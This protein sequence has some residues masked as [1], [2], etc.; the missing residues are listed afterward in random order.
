MVLNKSDLVEDPAS[1]VDEIARLAPGVPVHAVSSR[2]DGGVELL[3]SY[4]G[5]GQTGAL[6]GSSGVGKSTIVNSLIGHELLRTRDVRESDSRGRH[7]STAR[8]LVALPDGGVLIDTPGMRELQLWET[9]DAL[10]GAFADIDAMAANCRFRDCTH[11]HEPG[12]AVRAASTSGEL[13]AGR[14]ESYL[15]LREEQEFQARQQDQRALLEEKRKAKMMA[16]GPEQADKRRSTRNRSP[17]SVVRSPWSVSPW[18]D[19][20]SPVN[21]SL[22]QLQVTRDKDA[23]VER[24]LAALE[25]AAREGAEL[26]VFPELAFEWFHPQRPAGTNP[27]TSRSLCPGPTTERFQRAARSLGVAVVLNLYERDGGRAFDCSPVIDADGTLLGRTRMVHITDYPCFHEQG[28]YTPGD[29]GAPVYR[30]Q[31]W[32]ASASP[33]VTTVTTLNTCARWRWRRR[34]VVVPQAG[35]VG[36]WPEGLYEA[37]MRSPLF[38]TAISSRS[39]TA[40]ATRTALRSPGSRS[41]AIQRAG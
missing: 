20:N 5:P 13:A 11:Q 2:V 30:H 34:L 8:Q 33:S 41:S 1:Y 36:E 38:R 39:A 27:L 12:C 21:I 25:A 24:G 35:A 19:Y 29:T 28:Y 32:R 18:S 40:S 3:R 17:W 10:S 4:L 14:L 6:L 15:K 7:T 16:Q 22:V 9:G 37:E 23:N 31:G 26:V